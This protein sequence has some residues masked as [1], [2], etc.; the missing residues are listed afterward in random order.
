VVKTPTGGS[1]QPPITPASGIG[2][3]LL[4]YGRLHIWVGTCT[5]AHAHAHTYTH[6]HTHTH[7]HTH[8]HTHTQLNNKSYDWKR[9][10]ELPG[11]GDATQK[12]SIAIP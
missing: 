1:S 9:M 2:H 11:P 3:S 7:I 12:E 6:T 5:H 10:V 8:T 4:T